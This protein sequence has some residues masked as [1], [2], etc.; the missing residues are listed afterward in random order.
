MSMAHSKI[1]MIWSIARLLDSHQ[2]ALVEYLLGWQA[3]TVLY[4]QC[5][6]VQQC[7]MLVLMQ[8]F[9]PALGRYQHALKCKRA[10]TSGGRGNLRTR[11]ASLLLLEHRQVGHNEPGEGEAVQSTL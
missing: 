11:T 9:S 7:V 2:F 6:K 5:P 4:S 3:G 10:V 8:Q 1:Y